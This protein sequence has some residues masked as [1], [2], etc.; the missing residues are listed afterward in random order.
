MSH[1]LEGSIGSNSLPQ[2][3]TFT[4][5]GFSSS[6]STSTSTSLVLLGTSLGSIWIWQ[7]VRE[8][9]GA[10]TGG[11]TCRGRLLSVVNSAH[12]CSIVELEIF[13]MEGV[14]GVGGGRVASSGSDGSI[15]VWTLNEVVADK[16]VLPLEH[17]QVLEVGGEGGG[18]G[19]GAFVRSLCW[20][21]GGLVM[22][23]TDNST[24]YCAYN[25]EV[26][27]TE[28]ASEKE[29]VLMR[30]HMGKVRRL[31]VHPTNREVFCSV[32]SDHTIKMWS[33][34]H[35]H[36]QEWS[37][38]TPA[39]FSPSCVCFS[40]DGR[41][42]VVGSDENQ[43]LLLQEGEGEGGG[44]WQVKNKKTIPASKGGGGG[45]TEVKYNPYPSPGGHP[46]YLL[47]VGGRDGGVRLLD[48]ESLRPINILKGHTSNILRGHT[49]AIR[50]I[51]FGTQIGG[52]GGGGGGYV[53]QTSDATR[54]VLYWGGEGQQIT[55]PGDF[56]D[57]VWDSP[58]CVFGWG[59]HGL[60]DGLG[61]INCVS[62]S[63]DHSLVA[64]GGSQTVK[65]AIKL[66][67]YPCV[68]GS[69]PVLGGGHTSPVLDI[70]FVGL[71]GGGR[72]VV[73]AGGNDSCI[74]LWR[75]TDIN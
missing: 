35:H 53:M 73:S 14:G 55:A 71:E 5:F 38:R 59:V 41:Y 26:Q 44:M 40:P 56:R 52:G 43:L 57:A 25:E 64:S 1:L 72:G 46:R 42:L 61:D 48:G 58:S 74:F 39:D 16:E 30:C 27:N 70:G 50:S 3:A 7:Q 49:S 15:N 28:A 17:L 45:V 51:D 69:V 13:H 23:W 34:S 75:I 33:D 2:A 18:G 10:G 65:G 20:G 11:W 19:G 22:G 62:V 63:P 21:G 68:K 37:L 54:E 24:S 6:T 32:S 47:A 31:C 8:G 67:N 36:Q 12:D 9:G 4:S 29:V 66:C 60:F